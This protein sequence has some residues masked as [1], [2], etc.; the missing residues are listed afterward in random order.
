MQKA[1]HRQQQNGHRSDAVYLL[2]VFLLAGHVSTMLGELKYAIMPLGSKH[3]SHNH[4]QTASNTIN[5][6]TAKQ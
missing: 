1:W 5:I 3:S 6:V 4:D 2:C